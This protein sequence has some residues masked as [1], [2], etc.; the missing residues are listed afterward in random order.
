MANGDAILNIIQDSVVPKGIRVEVPIRKFLSASTTGLESNI[1]VFLVVYC[2][3]GRP[4]TRNEAD[5]YRSTTETEVAK[6]VPLRQNRIGRMV[7]KP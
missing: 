1:V 4:L 6:H 5:Q 2:G 3:E 7:S